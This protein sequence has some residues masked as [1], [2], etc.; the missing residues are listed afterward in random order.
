MTRNVRGVL[1]AVVAAPY[2]TVLLMFIGSL[3]AG[4]AKLDELPA[5][6]LM[7]SAGLLFLGIPLLSVSAILAAAIQHTGRYACLISIMSGILT[8]SG[9]ML[10]MYREVLQS[11]Q[12]Q[13]ILICG[14]LAGGICG[15]IYWRIAVRSKDP[16]PRAE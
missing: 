13:L 4:D 8:G 5:V 10:F 2:I 7:G 9:F 14:A 16:A 12:A 3:I 6:P 1:A 11:F 15:W